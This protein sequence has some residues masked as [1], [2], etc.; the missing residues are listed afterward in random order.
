MAAEIPSEL[1][2]TAAFRTELRRFLGRT[3]QVA[4]E[5]GLTPERYDLLLMIE[6][7]PGQRST[8]TDLC[9]ALQL[10]QTAVTELVKRATE[11]GL[12]AREPSAD[13]AR[14]SFI[15]LT[16]EGRRRLLH[17]FDALRADRA[18]LAEAFRLLR[19]RFRATAAGAGD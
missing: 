3:S 14:V 15:K 5:A 16:P 10:R 13:D 4:S 12:L 19:Q 17:V 18:A 1:E 2:R 6:A 7:A 8:V 9:E 11:A